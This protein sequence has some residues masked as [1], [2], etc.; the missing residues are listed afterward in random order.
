VEG[1]RRGNRRIEGSGR[2]KA[3]QA[4]SRGYL[5]YEGSEFEEED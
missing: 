2:E 4:S 3:G 1:L 5:D